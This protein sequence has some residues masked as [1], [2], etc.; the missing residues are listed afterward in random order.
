MSRRPASV[1]QADIARALR[2]ARQCGAGA[3]R[4]QPDGT[5]LINPQPEH[6][7]GKLKNLV[8]DDGEVVL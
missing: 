8:E 4:I 1:T 5:I 7:G 2:A 3:V 6:V